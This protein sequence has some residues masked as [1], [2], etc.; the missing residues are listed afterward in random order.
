MIQQARFQLSTQEQKILLY[1]ISKIK[2]KDKEFKSYEFNLAEFCNVCGID[3]DNGKN[4]INLKSTLKKLS[5]KS[6]WI[7]M[8]EK[9]ILLRWLNDVEISRNSGIIEVQFQEKMK[10][11]LLEIKKN[12]TQYELLY[13]LGM[14]SQYSIRLYEI[15]KSYEYKKNIVFEIEDLKRTLIADTYKLYGD[16]KRRVLEPAMTEINNLSDIRIAYEPVKQGRKYNKISFS[17]EEKTDFDE[18]LKTWKRIDEVINP[19]QVSLFDV[20]E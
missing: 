15:L 1:L 14:Q 16:F 10:P 5:D 13:I 11:F 2:P 12:F 6:M 18:R 20:I 3:M 8:D 9:E 7:K 17:I 4:Y 19:G